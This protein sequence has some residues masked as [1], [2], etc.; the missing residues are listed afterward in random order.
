MSD[1]KFNQWCIVELF[2]HQR[3]AGFVTETQIAG[4]GFIQV[5]VP[6]VRDGAKPFSRLYNPSA[7]YAINPV[8]EPIAREMAKRID[9][10]P[11]VAWDIGF[12]PQRQLAFRDE[13]QDDFQDH[14]L[15]EE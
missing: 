6:Q 1:D 5:D 13:F 14:D 8:T 4:A 9:T 10:R 12:D 3:I 2:G 7:V 11:I 15:D